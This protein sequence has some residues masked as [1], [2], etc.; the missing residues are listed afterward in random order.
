[1]AGS[2]R[3]VS[4][5]KDITP[6]TSGSRLITTANTGRWM[7]MSDSF[8]RRGLGR[9]RRRR[10]SRLAAMGWRDVAGRDLQTRAQ[11]AGAVDHDALAGLQALLDLDDARTARASDHIHALDAV[12]APDAVHEG[13]AADLHH[14]NFRN[15]QCRALGAEQAHVQQHARAQRMVAV[16]E[17][18]THGHRAGGRIDARIDGADLA[19]EGAT[20]PCHAGGADLVTDAERGQF[21]PAPGNQRACARCHRAWRSPWSASAACPG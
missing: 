3:R 11:L 9:D 17:I 1:M 14:R 10:I 18:G 2:S 12:V 8:I 5:V 15:H 19:L 20:R 6:S 7:E 4:R 16:G 13:I 21:L